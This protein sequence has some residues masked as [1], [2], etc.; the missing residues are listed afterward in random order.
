MSP[1]LC[2]LLAGATGDVLQDRCCNYRL[3][4]GGWYNALR[5][6]TMKEQE[7]LGRRCARWK[8]QLHLTEEPS[9][10]PRHGPR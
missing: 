7:T 5:V 8:L 9:Q 10:P 4:N 6:I 2:A 1:G 3:V